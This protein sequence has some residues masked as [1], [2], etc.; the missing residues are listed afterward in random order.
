MSGHDPFQRATAVVDL[1]AV[2]RNCSTIAAGLAE[3]S[4][5]CAVVKANGYGHGMLECADAALRWRRDPVRGRDGDGGIELR[6]RVGEEVPIFVMG[7][8]TDAELGRRAAGA[9]RRSRSG[10]PSSSR[11]SPSAPA[12]RSGPG[13]TSSTTPA[14]AG[15]ASAS[16]SR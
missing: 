2:E 7:A 13:S 3:G 16:R 15:S 12:S 10:G 8:L 11:S 9:T 5:L 6:E 1:G 4:E 14:W